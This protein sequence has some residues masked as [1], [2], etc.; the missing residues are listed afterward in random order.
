MAG[1]WDGAI[2]WI[3][4][5]TTEMLRLDSARSRFPAQLRSPSLRWWTGRWAG[6]NAARIFLCDPSSPFLAFIPNREKNTSYTLDTVPYPLLQLKLTLFQQLRGSSPNI[7]PPND[8]CFFMAKSSLE[9]HG[10][11]RA[12]SMSFLHLLT[13]PNY[14]FYYLRISPPQILVMFKK[15]HHRTSTLS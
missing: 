5:F 12:R 6:P 9:K 4:C 11:E 13:S 10:N 15:V 1:W 14:C 7:K 2:Y 3:Y 8:T